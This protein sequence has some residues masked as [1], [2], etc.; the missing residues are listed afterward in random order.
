MIDC[1]FKMDDK[2]SVSEKSV[3]TITPESEELIKKMFKEFNITVVRHKY[4][5]DYIKNYREEHKDKIKLTQQEYIRK[6]R[7]EVN[8][9]HREYYEKN[10]DK[11]RKYL[12]EKARERKKKNELNR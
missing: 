12:R 6:H 1:D 8:K 9:K 11:L 10:K 4:T 7:E 2:E 3:K 5:D